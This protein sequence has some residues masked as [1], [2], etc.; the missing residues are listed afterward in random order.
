MSFRAINRKYLEPASQLLMVLGIVAFC[1]P[2][3]MFW[4]SYG[5]TITLVGLIMFNI[6]NKIRP[7]QDPAEADERPRQGA[8]H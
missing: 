8:Q 5:V 4:H 6:T 3:S 1:Q 2:W 7:E